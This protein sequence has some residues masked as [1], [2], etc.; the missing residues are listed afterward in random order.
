[1]A[2]CTPFVHL[3]QAHLNGPSVSKSL[4]NQYV[5]FLS[6]ALILLHRPLF[7]P[8]KPCQPGPALQFPAKMR[9][10]RISFFL[11]LLIFAGRLRSRRSHRGGLA[12]LLSELQI[13]RSRA[14]RKPIRLPG[15]RQ[16]SSQLTPG[17]TPAR[18]MKRCPSTIRV[19]RVI[20][21]P[22]PR[23]VL[24]HNTCRFMKCRKLGSPNT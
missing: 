18:S 24:F 1:M 22:A 23:L 11:L 3:N 10:A 5:T 17:R 12:H 16:R 2:I 9:S 6:L 13:A 19:R 21:T 14:H 15:L 8:S 7:R 20:T 4:I